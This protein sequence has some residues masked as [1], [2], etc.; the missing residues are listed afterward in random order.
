MAVGDMFLK[1]DGIEGESTVDGHEGEI[2]IDSISWGVSN[3]GSQAY[4][5]GGGTGRADVSDVSFVKTVDKATSKLFLYCLSGKPISEAVLVQR[6]S[7]GD[8]PLDYEKIT[9]SDC[10]ISS[11]QKS[12]NGPSDSNHESFSLNFAAIKYEYF[13]QDED[14][15]G[16]PS[17]DFKWDVKK[18]K[19]Q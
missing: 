15:S 7:G 17:G 4:G 12:S 14:G 19:K 8:S 6:K 3:T 9:L 1:L 16:K 2:D 11:A 5:G 18:N 13:V 10:V